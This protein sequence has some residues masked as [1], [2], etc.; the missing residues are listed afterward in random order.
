[1]YVVGFSLLSNLGPTRIGSVPCCDFTMKFGGEL[2]RK[3][4]FFHWF[5]SRLR[6]LTLVS[7]ILVGLFPDAV[8]RVSVAVAVS[9]LGT[10][11]W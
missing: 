6:A 2:L 10:L 8:S 9:A 3:V 5:R 4:L 11:L 7:D 1:M